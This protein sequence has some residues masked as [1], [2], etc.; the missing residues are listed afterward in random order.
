MARKKKEV[1]E[2]V[3]DLQIYVAT[4][5]LQ[6]SINSKNYSVREGEQ[7]FLTKSEFNLFRQYL[8]EAK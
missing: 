3:S 5:D 2:A 7:I 4:K 1:V 8:K 6:G